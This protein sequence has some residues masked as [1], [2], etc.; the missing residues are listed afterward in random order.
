MGS[1]F[2]TFLRRFAQTWNYCEMYFFLEEICRNMQK[3]CDCRRNMQRKVGKIEIW[4]RRIFHRRN[5]NKE[6]LKWRKYAETKVW[7]GV[8]WRYKWKLQ[9]RIVNFFIKHIHTY[10]YARKDN[11]NLLS[12]F[13]TGVLILKRFPLVLQFK[14]YYW[15]LIR[16]TTYPQVKPPLGSESSN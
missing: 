11:L 10:T 14:T 2:C 8:T 4:S 13:F 5:L 16:S 3:N 6:T 9:R 1:T 12:H 7:Y 15:H